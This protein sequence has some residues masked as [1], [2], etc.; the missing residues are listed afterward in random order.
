MIDEIMY[1]GIIEKDYS[2][3]DE[4]VDELMEGGSSD[5]NRFISAS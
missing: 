1:L 3:I 2:R 5:K 4:I